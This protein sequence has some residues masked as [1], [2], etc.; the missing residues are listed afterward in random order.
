MSD[1]DQALA[2]EVVVAAVGAVTARLHGDVPSLGVLC[3]DLLGGGDQ[4][5]AYAFVA[6]TDVA[7]LLVKL[8]AAEVGQPP[9]R[10]LE[11]L[12]QELAEVIAASA[13]S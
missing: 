3:G 11:I 13:A 1:C 8:C 12:G 2:A 7:A 10:V 9:E 4:R 5:A 6:L